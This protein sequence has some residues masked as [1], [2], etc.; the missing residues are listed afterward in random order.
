MMMVS[1]TPKQ[2]MILVET[3]FGNMKIKL[4]DTTPGHRDNFKKLAKE[5]YYDGSLFHRVIP[6]FMIQGGDPNSIGA[7]PEARLGNGGPGY[8]QPAEIGAF[9][10]KGAI[11]AA[12][13]QNPEK[14]S[15]G[16]QFYI[17]HGNTV[18]AEQLNSFASQKG[19]TYSAEDIA[20][21]TK[22][23]G[24]PFLD[25]DYTVFGEVVEGLDVIDKIA[26]TKIGNSDRPMSEV[27]MK[28]KVVK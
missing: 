23:G 15:S 17:V 24:A 27:K 9:H 21:Y 3:D 16:S 25:N 1:C 18:T 6:K 10:F 8:T 2:E 26:A 20:K 5:G 4:Y 12:R 7:A 11:A 28:V 19:I 14:N 13:T 22:V